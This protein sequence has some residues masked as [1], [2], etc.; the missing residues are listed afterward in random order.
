MS[1]SE[2]SFHIKHRLYIELFGS[3]INTMTE[4]YD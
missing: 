2:I 4:E 1:T 3:I